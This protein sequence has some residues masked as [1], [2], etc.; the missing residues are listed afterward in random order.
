[1][2]F[3]PIGRGISEFGAQKKKCAAA[4]EVSEIQVEWSVKYLNFDSSDTDE[5]EYT[6]RESRLRLRIFS[7]NNKF[8]ELV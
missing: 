6:W 4:S 1:M 7:Y 3:R 8:E 5:R 2:V